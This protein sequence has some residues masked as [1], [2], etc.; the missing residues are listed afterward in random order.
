MKLERYWVEHNGDCWQ[1][2]FPEEQAE[3]SQLHETVQ[4]AIE[5]IQEVT[6]HVPVTVKARDG[7]VN[8]ERTFVCGTRAVVHLRPGVWRV[9]C[10]T[11]GA[12]GSVAHMAARDA[13]RA[14]IRDSNK[15]C[16]A[17]GAS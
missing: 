13:N 16:R 17:C 6:K 5:Y 14:A 1:S 2:V 9:V 4:D 11:C 15:P 3:L 10:A 12:G 8:P 7:F